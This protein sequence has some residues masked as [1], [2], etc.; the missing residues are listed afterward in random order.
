M[1]RTSNFIVPHDPELVRLKRDLE[2]ARHAILGLMS[3]PARDILSRY[4]QCASR[5]EVREWESK[6]VDQ[7]VNLATPLPPRSQYEGER[8]YCP[9]CGGSAQDIYNSQRGFSLPVGVERH[10]SGWGNTHQCDVTVAA[11]GLARDWAR[12]K[13]QE[14]ERRE[15]AEAQA[16]IA[17]RRATETLYRV[18]PDGEPELM[19]GRYQWRPVRDNKGLAWAEERLEELGFKITLDD[20]VKSYTQEH[21]GVIVYADPREEGRIEFRVY[22]FPLPPAPRKS[23]R[24]PDFRFIPQFFLMDAWKNDLRQKYAARLAEAVRRLTASKPDRDVQ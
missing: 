13:F 14:S 5:A 19:G 11:F 15:E 18:G 20:R 16:Q 12:D 7:L 6:V 4:Y 22:N 24:R 1:P 9:L 10:L 8:A 3:E 2:N 23:R 17:K 21:P